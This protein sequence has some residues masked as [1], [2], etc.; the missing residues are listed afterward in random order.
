MTGWLLHDNEDIHEFVFPEFTLE[1]GATVN[2]WTKSGTNTTTDLYWGLGSAIWNNGG[3]MVY[4]KD[5]ANKIIST[6][7]YAG[8]GVDVVCNN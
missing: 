8:N 4:L 7:T 5:D 3:D 1:A 6:C 2:I